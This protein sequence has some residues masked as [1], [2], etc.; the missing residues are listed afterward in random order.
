MNRHFIAI[1]AVSMLLSCG[2][3]STGP[4]DLAPTTE[5]SSTVAGE[6]ATPAPVAPSVGPGGDGFSWRIVSVG[7]RWEVELT[8][9]ERTRPVFI[10]CYEDPDRN[11]ATQELHDV[12]RGEIL[13]G[14]TRVFSAETPCGNWQCDA[15]EGEFV[16][17]TSPFFGSNLILGRIGRRS[18]GACDPP[19][20]P[21]CT[22]CPPPPPVCN[23]SELVRDADAECEF[24]FELD[25]M[26]CTFTCLPPLECNV[27]ELV[28]EATL[29]CGEEQFSLDFDECTFE[30]DPPPPPPECTEDVLFLEAKKECGEDNVKSL[31]VFNCT[32][33][34]IDN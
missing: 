5:R 31:D 29:E 14:K 17:K 15:V 12:T 6:P 1:T 23:V 4:T 28:A 13:G 9:N 22:D 10:A 2:A 27:P 34:C 16:P 25:V 18:G 20:P 30:C 19:P 33:E 32:F 8:N 3:Q 24:D 7:E 26:A 21:V 11:I